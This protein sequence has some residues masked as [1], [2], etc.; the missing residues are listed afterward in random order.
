MRLACAVIYV[1]DF[2]RM[3]DLYRQILGVEP[4]DTQP[5][6]TWALFDTG[7]TRLAL[8]AIPAE[9][10]QN[11]DVASPPKARESGP[12][13]LIFAVDNVPAER[14]R[15]EAMGMTTLQ[16]PWQG[17]DEACEV[18]DPEGNIFQISSVSL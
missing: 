17:V 10:A 8:H 16:R 7:G 12:V 9:I 1:R 13:K 6:D 3:R 14:R 5:R 11:I 15:L 4:V 18:V 2:T